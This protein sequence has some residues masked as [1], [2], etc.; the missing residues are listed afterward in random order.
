[1]EEEQ[2]QQIKVHCITELSLLDNKATYR[3]ISYS[4]KDKIEEGI[5]LIDLNLNFIIPAQDRFSILKYRDKTFKIKNII[6]LNKSNLDDISFT[7]NGL[8]YSLSD[9]LVS[10]VKDTLIEDMLTGERDDY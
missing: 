4:Y 7:H 10:K 6:F 2:K 8:D 1:M 3:C 5:G 9:E